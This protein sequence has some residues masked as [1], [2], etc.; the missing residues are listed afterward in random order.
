MRV[1]ATLTTLPGRYDSLLNT[2]KSLHAQTIKL[3]A[4]YL[5]LP[6]KARRLNKIYDEPGD[7]IKSLCNIIRTDVD[8]GPICKLYGA[9]MKEQ[10]PDTIIITFDD[11]IVYPNNIVEC[12]LEKHKIQPDAAISGLA[13]LIKHGLFFFSM[14]SNVDKPK[15]YQ[16]FICINI[17][18]EGRKM[19]ILAG[20]AGALYKRGFFPTQEK[21]Y[22]DFFSYALYHEDF[23]KNDDIIISGY[24]SKNNI[25]RYTF[26]DLPMIEHNDPHE[27]ALSYNTI[28]MFYSMSNCIKVSKEYGMYETSEEAYISD[29]AAFKMIMIFII[30]FIIILIILSTIYDF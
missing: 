21:L 17:N 25:N 19:D 7:E 29:T 27:N 13:W 15:K 2:L 24:L 14:Q 6:H 10:D 9:L 3:D 8:Y 16:S 30:I 1:V 22:E 20:V 18:K 4:I 28:K 23:F 11:D 5:T 26:G 12:L